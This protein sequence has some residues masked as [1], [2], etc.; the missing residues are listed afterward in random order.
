MDLRP[1]FVCGATASGK[2]ARAVVL[3]EELGGEIV[4]ADAF[5]LYRGV[6]TLTAAPEA[7]TQGRVRHHLFSVWEP[8]E[9]GDAGRYLCEA[10]PKLEEIQGAGRVPIVVGGSGLYLKFLTHGP[11]P[12]PKGDPRLRAEF[13]GRSL[14]DLLGQLEQL[15]PVEAGQVDRGNRRYVERALEICLLTG[16]RASQLRTKWDLQRETLEKNLRGECLERPRPELH[17]RIEQRVSAMLEGGAID[18][19]QALEGVG[20]SWEKAI[21]VSQ[22]RALLRGE[23]DRERCEELIVYAT[24]QYAKR[25]E[26]W[27]RKERWLERR[28][29]T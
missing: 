13:R 20:G 11:S 28:C 17:R 22:I 6:E 15:D 5:Q 23:I 25:Q 1:Y 16:E 14:T 26:T 7:E 18:E 19:V 10:K 12:L 8:G 27:L 24:R 9:Q 29:V 3:A 2:T 4:N 21:G